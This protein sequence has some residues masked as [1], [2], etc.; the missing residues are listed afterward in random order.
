LIAELASLDQLQPITNNIMYTNVNNVSS[1]HRRFRVVSV[2]KL[3]S[4]QSSN[5]DFKIIIT[6]A[7]NPPMLLTRYFKVSLK[8]P[9]TIQHIEPDPLERS[10]SGI[11]RRAVYGVRTRCHLSRHIATKCRTPFRE[12]LNIPT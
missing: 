1:T 5:L 6:S 7:L 10:R 11:W 8:T 9:V 3:S 12:K 4:E 2:T